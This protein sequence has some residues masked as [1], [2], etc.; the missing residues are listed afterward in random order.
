MNNPR[1]L[2]STYGPIIQKKKEN[3]ESGR[4]IESSL[5]AAAGNGGGRA[6]RTISV[7]SDAVTNT[8]SPQTNKDNEPQRDVPMDSLCCGSDKLIS[9]HRARYRGVNHRQTQI[10]T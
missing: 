8:R 6:R 7:H 1:C 5:S 4:Q 9:D 2:L 3:V 10:N